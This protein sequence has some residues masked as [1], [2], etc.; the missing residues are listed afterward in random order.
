MGKYGTK[1]DYCSSKEAACVVQPL[2]HSLS[3]ELELTLVRLQCASSAPPVNLQC[4]S[5]EPP[6]RLRYVSTAAEKSVLEYGT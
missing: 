3:A 5:S 2:G 1:L 4:T 6:V